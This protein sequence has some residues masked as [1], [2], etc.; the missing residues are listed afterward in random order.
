MSQKDWVIKTVVPSAPDS[1]L[2]PNRAFR[3]GGWYP[4]VEAARNLRAM[5]QYA[6]K[7]SAPTR[8]LLGPVVV[9][10]VIEW[11]ARRHTVDFDAAVASL[12]PVLDGLTDAG[13]WLDDAQVVGMTIRQTRGEGRV[14]L[15]AR[16]SPNGEEVMRMPAKKKGE[17]PFAKK[18]EKMS[19]GKEKMCPKCKKAKSKCKC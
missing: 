13:W 12:K 5:A 4:R 1:A 17:N 14:L 10:A 3:K 8:P 19:E 9:D 7:A 15:T 16:L 2:M 11:P 6:G 18:D